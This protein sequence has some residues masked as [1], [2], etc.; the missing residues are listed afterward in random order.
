MI[1]AIIA[2]SDVVIKAQGV[3]WGREAAWWGL[4]ATYGAVYVLNLASLSVVRD[5][6]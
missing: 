5:D 6:T 2:L 3:G 1:V 4:V